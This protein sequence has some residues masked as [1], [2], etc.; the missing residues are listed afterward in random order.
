MEPVDEALADLAD[1]VLALAR[2][3]H[4]HT[5]ADPQVVPLTATEVNVMRYIDHNPSSTPSAVAA[6]VGLQRSN[7]SK[8]LRSLEAHGLI[9]RA[10]DGDDGRQ[11]VLTPTT[12]AA[13]NLARL[14]SQWS[15]LLAGAAA[16][17]D[18]DIDT[19]LAVLRALER[20]LQPRT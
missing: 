15:H 9:H 8:T 19:A 7:L 10:A 2:T 1:S 14:R 18:S 4:A 3:I 6:A 17:A 16:P 12:R 11:S 5:R 13:D 20:G